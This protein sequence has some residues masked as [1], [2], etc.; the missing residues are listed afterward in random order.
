MF[1]LSSKLINYKIKTFYRTYI[2]IN[3]ENLHKKYILLGL[4]IVL[5]SISFKAI[6]QDNFS[7]DGREFRF[8]FLDNYFTF[9]KISFVINSKTPKNSVTISCASYSETFN[10]WGKDTQINYFRSIGTPTASQFNASRSILITAIEPITLMAMN[11]A[12]NSTD[13]T[14][15]IPTEKIPSNPVYY[16]NTIRG[17]QSIG[18]SNNSLF[19]IVALEDGVRVNIM[20]TADSKTSLSKNLLFQTTLNKG[21]IYRAQAQDSQSFA[22]TKIWNTNGCKKFAVFEGA[23]CSFVEYN[24]S[25][26][27]GCDHLYNQTIPLQYLGKEYTTIPFVGNLNGYNYQVIATENNSN[28]FIDGNLVAILNEGEVLKSNESS[29]N[30]L[31]IQS[32]KKIS[33]SQ[34]MR[35][36]GCNGHPNNLGNPSMIS[37]LPSTQT[38]THVQFSYTTTSNISNNSS[39][40][41]EFYLGIIAK[42]GKLNEI[43]LNGV[44][45]DTQSFIE[46]CGYLIGYLSLNPSLNYTLQSKTGIQAYLYALGRDESYATAL[47]SNLSN[48][49]TELKVFE[50]KLSTCDSS[51]QF[52]F[53]ASSDSLALY[54]WNFGDGTTA[55]GDSVTKQYNRVG[56]YSLK[57]AIQYPNNV[58]CNEDSIIKSIEVYKKP[59]FELGKDSTLCIGKVISIEP[60]NL[61]KAN[62]LWSNGSSSNRIA[63]N[64]TQ[65]VWLR[66]TDS[67][68]CVF[69]DTIQIT[70]KS[71]DTN[72]IIIPNV[73]TP[74]KIQNGSSIGDEINDY[75]EVKMIGYDQLKGI[76]FNRWGDIIYEFNYPNQEFW[77]GCINNDISRPCTDGTYYYLYEFTNSSTKLVK[78]VNGVVRLIR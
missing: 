24:N 60:I 70:F 75:F 65:K 43:L 28:I 40:P 18:L 33:V 15:I 63:I 68:S 5:T 16:I 3:T 27:R 25:S 64:N 52:I 47:S 29:N 35:S 51:Y 59:Y 23:I 73:F 26:C 50:N 2:C 9:E 41:S 22:G 4:I 1:N 8:C 78:K 38:I 55:S 7:N 77:N 6:G 54:S 71:C 12:L 49:Q 10:I 61:L 37:V 39:T 21:Q 19:T 57:L 67:N 72:N 69:S 11:N 76:I 56:I 36:G 74:F 58:G 66:V 30:S 14:T 62:Y 13:I 34:L 53:K 20:P 31:C 17:D 32:D 45:I 46:K 42:K 48:T 44:L